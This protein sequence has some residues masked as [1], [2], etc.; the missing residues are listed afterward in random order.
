ITGAL[1]ATLSSSCT[2]GG[3]EP[4]MDPGHGTFLVP[5]SR[6]DAISDIRTEGVCEVF[7]PTDGCDAGGCFEP[8]DG[9]PRLR[10]LVIGREQ[11]NCTV[12][13]EFSDGCPPAELKY[14]FGG[15]L[16]NC[17]SETCS[18]SASESLDAAC[19]VDGGM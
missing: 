12:T 13:V 7:A 6:N 16:D 19:N 2:D 14:E 18:R 11:G 1:L 10:F 15:P 17:C 5:E 9:E 4:C 8:P 3:K